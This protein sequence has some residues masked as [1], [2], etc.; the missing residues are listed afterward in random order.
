MLH[1]IQNVDRRVRVIDA[2]GWF[3]VE[4]RATRPQWTVNRMSPITT[5]EVIL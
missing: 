5:G 2:R 4:L 3:D 1:R